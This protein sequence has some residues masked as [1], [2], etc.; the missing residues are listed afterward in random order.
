MKLAVI[1]SGYVGLVTGACFAKLGHRVVCVDHDAKKIRM[2]KAGKV[3]FYEPGLHEIV[4]ENVAAK[5]LSFTTEIAK[6]V[7]HCEI[8]FI[9]VHTPPQPDGGADLTF[10]EKVAKQVAVHLR[11]YC[12]IVEK[13][14]VPVE[15]GEWVYKTIRRNVRRGIQFDVASN[16]EFLREGSALHDF[17]KPDRIVLGVSSARAEKLLRRLYATMKAPMLVTDIKSAELIKHASNSFLAMKISFANA[18]ARVCDAVGADVEKV[19]QGMGLDPRIGNQFLRAGIGFGGS[20]FPKDV[21]AFLHISRRLGIRFDLLAEILGINDTQGQY[22]VQKIQKSMRSL[23]GKT[24]CVLGLA[25]KSDTDDMRCAP[26]LAIIPALQKAG[27]R[28][29]AY[30][31]QAM[32]KARSIFKKVRFAEDP[33]EAAKDADAIVLLTEWKEFLN[34]DW[35]RMRRVAR[36][37]LV[38]DGRNLFS[39]QE[40]K[41]NGFRYVSIGRPSK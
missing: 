34:I 16:P 9:C 27:A 13:S 39:P 22:F 37:H 10:V 4:T 33:Y 5:R 17:A 40:M 7:N 19:T 25:F 6:V 36:K 24:L 18:I 3:P 14:T 21:S 28:I 31:P 30:D 1:G 35:A 29:H 2:L 11:K 20:C 41:E 38:F 32:S 12:L 26:S 23:E 15:T 8:L